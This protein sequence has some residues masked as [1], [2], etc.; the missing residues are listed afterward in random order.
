MAAFSLIPV[1]DA[2]TRFFYYPADAEHT[3]NL[4]GKTVIPG[5]PEGGGQWLVKDLPVIPQKGQLSLLLRAPHPGFPP[6]VA[7]EVHKGGQSILSATWNTAENAAWCIESLP[8]T[9]GTCSLHLA[10]VFPG[11][12]FVPKLP[13]RLG[14]IYSAD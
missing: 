2:G 6:F 7:I 12:P 5:M 1:G 3:V 8:V 4:V 13:V 14:V 10:Q 9:P 11:V